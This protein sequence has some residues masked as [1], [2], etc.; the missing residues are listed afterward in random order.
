MEYKT[1][2]GMKVLNGRSAQGISAFIQG[3]LNDIPGGSAVGMHELARELREKFPHIDKRQSYTRIGMVLTRAGNKGKYIKLSD[4]SDYVAIG[5]AK[6]HMTV[7]EEVK[8]T[9][10]D[11]GEQWVEGAE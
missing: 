6:D 8:H 3:I 2:D 1:A 5:W 4:S 9:V 11:E 10:V 7:E